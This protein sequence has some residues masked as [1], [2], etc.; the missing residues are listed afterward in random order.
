MNTLEEHP[1]RT[2][3]QNILDRC[4]VNAT[5]YGV[6]L[7]QSKEFP[8]DGQTPT[9]LIMAPKV[10]HDE[11]WLTASL[12]LYDYLSKQGFP[13]VSVEIAGH[14][15]FRSLIYTPVEKANAMHNT[16][17]KVLECILKEVDLR[18]CCAVECLLHG[19][20]HDTLGNPPTVLVT[21]DRQSTRKWKNIRE[22]IVNILEQFALI[23][24]AVKVLK[25]F[26][27][28]ARDGM[29][30]QFPATIWGSKAKLGGS[31][32][33]NDS[34]EVSGTFGGYLEIQNSNRIWHKVGITC[35]HVVLPQLKDKLH[36][37]DDWHRKG[38][39]FGDQ[40]A[41]ALRPIQPSASDYTEYIQQTKDEISSATNDPD[42]QR[43][44]VL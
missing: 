17:D 7:R 22:D 16:W 24:V 9:V 29:G 14:R 36:K 20:S 44:N 19:Y 28:Q 27:V 26:I 25:G 12:G 3:I 41:K 6:V 2:T 37:F 43:R 4:G 21:V 38:I 5:E 13:H 18:G 1:H 42:F 8:Q 15:V 32:G 23:G 35:Y 39:Q 10:K 11:T 34:K 30:M 31:M 40:K 33:P